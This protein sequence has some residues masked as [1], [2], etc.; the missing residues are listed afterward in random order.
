MSVSPLIS[1]VVPIYN[2]ADYLPKC[3]DSIL[4]QSYTNIEVLL[5]DDGSTDDSGQICDAYLSEDSRIRVIH[6]AN[7]GLSDARNA[8]LDCCKGEYVT[9]IDSDDWVHRQ[10][11]E[12]LYANLVR[13]FA[14]ISTVKFMRVDD[15][16]TV[17]TISDKTLIYDSD[18]AISA[19]LYQNKLDNSVCAKLFDIHL[20]DGLRFKKGIG[21]ED[22]QIFYRIYERAD[23]VAYSPSKLY[24]YRR[25][26]DSYLHTFTMRRVDVLDV[27]DEMEVYMQTRNPL[28]LKAVGS[29]KLSANFNIFMLMAIN[30]VRNDEV[31][32]RCWNNICRL[33]WQSL[34]DT[35]VRV[36]NKLGILASLMGR[37][38]L[39]A[40]FRIIKS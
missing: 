39:Y 5:V 17:T 27:V 14:D 8:G 37:R 38:V 21:Y 28:M 1:V 33:R 19:T 23:R 7:G 36:K 25:R 34:F 16:E 3:V 9:F 20:F 26:G 11:L 22:L 4:A 10:Y 15:E 29:R 18:E 2:V 40:L 32:S 31:E 12:L 24:F 30:G 13:F 35:R 6:K